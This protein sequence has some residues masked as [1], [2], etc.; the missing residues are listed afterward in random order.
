ME[1]ELDTELRDASGN[2][3][4]A[5][6]APHLTDPLLAAVLGIGREL[7]VRA[8][9]DRA[10]T[11]AVELT[12]ATRAELTVL[13]REGELTDRATAGPDGPL[14]PGLIEQVRVTDSAVGTLRVAR[15]ADEPAK[16]DRSHVVL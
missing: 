16:S 5:V 9:L 8:V 14:S 3:A 13:G 12:H 15:T 4:V 10:V 1:A 2:G 11:A 6:H 7:S